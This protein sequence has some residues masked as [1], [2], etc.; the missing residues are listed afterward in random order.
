MKV[1]H[2]S[3]GEGVGGAAL[4]RRDIP[5]DELPRGDHRA[6]WGMTWPPRREEAPAG[7]AP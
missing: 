6:R 3:E 4:E 5:G 2:S 7:V 1:V